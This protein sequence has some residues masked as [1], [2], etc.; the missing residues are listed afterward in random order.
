MMRALTVFE[1]MYGNTR[2]V[3]DS[4]AGGLGRFFDVS[5]VPV[6]D[7]SPSLVNSA[8]L[9]V[10]GGPTHLHGLSSTTS[11]KMAREAAEKP[12]SGLVLEPSAVGEGLRDWLDA[13]PRGNGWTAA[14]DTRIEGSALITGRASTGIAR[15]LRRRGYHLALPPESFLV[16][17]EGHLLDGELRRATAWGAALG[18]QLGL[19]PVAS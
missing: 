14:F 1:S 12:G 6:A 18:R 3:A 19:Q 4:I 11:R 5:V 10:V 7:A 17:K 13:I 16:D 8:V 15:R 2:S 9:L